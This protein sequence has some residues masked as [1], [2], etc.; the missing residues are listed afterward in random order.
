MA[1]AYSTDLRWRVIEKKQIGKT[2]KE[3]TSDLSVSKSFVYNMI[4][5]EKT[6]GKVEIEKEK[7]G[8]KPTLGKRDQEN[9]AK[10]IEKTPD[11]TLEEIKEELG[12]T[13]SASTLCNVINHVLKLR[14]KKNFASGRTKET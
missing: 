4:E 5:L 10:L 11:V 8:P 12:L 14:Y 1:K 9:I 2:V 7:P 6:T 3:I 13:V